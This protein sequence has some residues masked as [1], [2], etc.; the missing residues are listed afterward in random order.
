M[1]VQTPKKRKVMQWIVPLGF[2]L[3]IIAF[4]YEKWSDF[5]HQKPDGTTELKE[6]RKRQ[7]NDKVKRMRE[8]CEV[9]SL[10]AKA[11]GMYECL[12]CPQGVFYLK[13][14]E[15]WKY[16][17]TIQKNRYKEPYIKRMNVYKKTEY[18][19]N[20]QTAMEMEVTLI[21][22]YPLIPE[23]MAR[24]IKPKPSE[25]YRFRLARPPGNLSDE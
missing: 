20:C 23:N 5:A 15:V 14:H 3:C 22:K 11:D 12:H 8:R 7:L 1:N 25:P 16:G 2:L 13:K 10:R 24:P 21:G 6:S 17:R 4:A 19:G 9:Y 18:M